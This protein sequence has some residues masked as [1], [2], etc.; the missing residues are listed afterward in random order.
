MN[1]AGAGAALDRILLATD[2]IR[3]AEIRQSVALAD[4]A[5]SYSVDLDTLI[6]QLAEKTIHPGEDGT[7]GVSEF[8]CLE[9]GPAL[10]VS[11]RTA[12]TMVAGVLN[13]KHR[14]PRTWDSFLRG[15][16]PRWHADILVDMTSGLGAPAAAWV[17]ERI[18]RQVGRL[19]LQRLKR[20]TRGWVAQ[21]DPT[22][23]AERE[24]LARQGR[25]VHFGN[26]SGGTTDVWASLASRDA[27]A[28][29]R[30]LSE[31]AVAMGESGDERSH[32]QRRAAALGMLSDPAGALSWLTGS[33]TSTETGGARRCSR[34]RTI[35]YVHL[36]E[37]TLVDP[38]SGVARI[39]GFGPLTMESLPEFLAGTHVT[40]R[41][42]VDDS[43]IAPVDSYE[44]PE[45]LR[46]A[47]GRGS[48]FEA[49]PFTSTSSEHL[50]LDHIVAYKF[51][52]L[53]EPRQTRVNGLA[54]LA[55]L[56][57]RA[58]TLGAWKVRS[59]GLGELCWTSPLGRSYIVGPRGTRPSAAMIRRRE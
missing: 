52:H 20:L 48:P 44:I 50:D 16:V 51:G 14:H 1:K 31:L 39:D 7:P 10:G 4:L 23:A 28:L 36:A 47:V 53:W 25:R 46:D 6:P 26:D 34:G 21:A 3:S 45:Q 35:V 17:D 32:D 37:E 41:P 59:R 55:R 33:T 40:I 56:V 29:D 38:E 9:L 13:L 2:E 18:A 19:S 43:R 57:H 30:T 8:L 15:L 12:F 22:L 58:K 5:E 27:A 54:P 42:V 24:A 11:R 49:F